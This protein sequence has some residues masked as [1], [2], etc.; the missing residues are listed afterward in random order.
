MEKIYRKILVG[1]D[2]SLLKRVDLLLR[3][4]RTHWAR[5]RLVNW[6]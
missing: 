2:K 4:A 5:V 1:F 6:T 3:E